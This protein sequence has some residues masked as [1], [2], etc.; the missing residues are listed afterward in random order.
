MKLRLDSRI[1]LGT[2]EYPFLSIAIALGLILLSLFLP[3]FL[4]YAA[5]AICLYRVFRYDAKV[6]ATDYCVL[7]PTARL[8]RTAGNMNLLV[9]L[10]LIA[11]VWYLVRGKIRINRALVI[12]ILLLNYLL[13]RMQ[14]NI[15]DFVLCFGQIFVLFV[16]LP[17]QNAE[18]S[19]RAIKAFLWSIILISLYAMPFRK[20]DQMISIRGAESI[21]IWGTNLKRF[22][23]FEGDPNYYSSLILIGLA[24]LCK[25][26]E[27][28][29]MR[30]WLFWLQAI[31]L[32]V[33]GALTYSKSFL[34]VLILLGGIYIIWQFWNRKAFKGIFFT[35]VAVIGGMYLLFDASSPFA[36]IMER[37]T[38]SKDLS[39]FTTNRSEIFVWYWDA[40]T[41]SI[42]TA[43][44]GHG[45]N[46]LLLQGRD[47]HNLYLE[48]T[49]HVGL[50]GLLLIL[51]LY[52]SMIRDVIRHDPV[53]KKQSLL[54]KY[55]V[56]IIIAVTYMALQGMFSVITY[57]G[58]FLAFVSVYLTKAETKP[59]E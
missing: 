45:L 14:M 38:S 7:M 16:L 35:A 58:L 1:R 46:A 23:S 27:T 37:L 32:T 42:S 36:V 53:I 21:A 44:F 28:G 5:F 18:S 19:E 39:D 52:G 3:V 49:Y 57:E 20:T 26:Q 22:S 48:I 11:G 59:G 25:L 6:F 34:L 56:I 17:K 24:L 30:S 51:A 43:L 2:T 50:V 8:F 47:P 9:W 40:I 29:K 41:E 54:V 15:N 55:A 31:I 12:L 33:L 13:L 4:C 10:C